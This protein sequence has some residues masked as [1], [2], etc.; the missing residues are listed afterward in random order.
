MASGRKSK[1]DG[2]RC[3]MTPDVIVDLRNQFG[4]VRDQGERPTCMAFAA[5]DV[6]SFARDSLD[7]L[8]AEYAFYH[9]VHR[10]LTPDRTKGVSFSAMV[11]TIAM[12]GQPM[13]SGWPYLSDLQANDPWTPPAS[14]G[15]IYRRNTRTIVNA[16]KEIFDALLTGS[17]VILG[18]EISNSFYNLRAGDV[19][20]V[21]NEA[22]AGRHALIA[23]G[24]GVQNSA[25]CLL[26]RNSWG[27]GWGEFGHGWIHEDYL[28]PRLIVAGIMK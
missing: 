5:S 26:L 27:T 4:P 12:D 8:S 3:I 7:M 25:H 21:A 6:H 24:L 15:T 9:A 14:P 19:L 18:M 28:A 1:K 10:Q 16:L 2:D 23:V 17:P 13:E 20:P 22:L 11:D